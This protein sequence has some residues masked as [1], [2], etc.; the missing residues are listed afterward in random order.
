MR[1]KKVHSGLKETALSV[2]RARED[3]GSAVEG[4]NLVER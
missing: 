1:T 4:R 3:L 2:D